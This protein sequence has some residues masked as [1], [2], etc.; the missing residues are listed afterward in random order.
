MTITNLE[1]LLADVAAAVQAGKLT[2]PAGE[3]IRTWLTQPH[4]AGFSAQLVEHLAA[5]QWAALDD[6]FWT[7]IPFGTG[8]R[9]GR[10]Y[11]IGTAAIN[12]RTIGES[13]QGLAD[14]VKRLGGKHPGNGGNL[15][16]AVAYDTR[17]RSR[18]FAELCSEIM[19]SNGFKVWFL[20][21]YRS[22]PELSTA[23]RL[24]HCSCGLMI[25]ASHNPPSDN[26]VKVYWSDGAQLLPPHDKGVIDCVM[27]TTTI[28][29][30]PW[31]EAVA[32]G[33][34]E[35][36]E[37]EI[38]GAFQKAVVSQ[39]LPGPRKLNIL[40]S[41]M[42]GV[43]A[44]S[45]LP[46]LAA[47]GFDD[48]ELFAPHADANGDFPNVPGHV[49]N[50]ENPATFAAMIEHA[51]KVGADLVLS[52]DP[53]ADRLG[54]AAPD[55]DGQWQIITGNQIGALLTDYVLEQRRLQR[56]LNATSYIV[57]T[58]VTSEIIRR[59]AESYGVACHG[60]LPVGFKY[61]AA[62]IDEVGPEGFV[63]GTE[64]SHGYLAGTHARD[65]DATVAALLVAELA[66]KVKSAGLSLPAKL[67]ALFWQHGCHVEQQISRTLP[68]AEG[69]QTMRRMMEMLRSSPPAELGGLRVIRSR[70]YLNGRQV[71]ADGEASPLTGPK[72]DMVMLDLEC[73]GN[74]VAIRPSGTEP[75]LK[76][77]LFAYEPPELIG[78][79]EITKA[80]LR[81]RLA[82]I[83]A[84]VHRL[85]A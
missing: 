37:K 31:A 40:Y 38:D 42:H 3:N 48:V 18:E 78:D 55:D 15:S 13:A 63:L 51:Q 43:G 4:F 70:D 68:G 85:E 14:Y 34:I 24:K 19:A 64:E 17:H 57:K 20:D 12:D 82:K 28:T 80:E 39:S 54:C 76:V 49:A 27:N 73:D 67:D 36:C 53:D 62:K 16:C 61:I 65:K 75:K 26:A 74:Y 25:T 5:G 60:D 79:L 11:P 22:T 44:A 1:K 41:P 2:P 47:A 66:A 21:G 29:R 6:V 35:M 77:Y 84:D 32:A 9:R 56:T 52:S 72:T 46:V 30:Q 71:S 10:M 69:M 58:L 7:T 81:E 45:V 8:G 33:K 50:P 23:V 59:I 83:A